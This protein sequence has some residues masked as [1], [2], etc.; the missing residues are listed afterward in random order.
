MAAPEPDRYRRAPTR[1]ANPHPSRRPRRWRVPA[2]VIP[3]TPAAALPGDDEVLRVLA[4][5]RDHGHRD[6]GH[7]VALVVGGGGM[8]GAYSG[9]MAHALED[10]GLTG[11]FDAVY[12]SSAGAFV[13]SGALLGSGRGSAHIF[14]EDMACRE[15]IDP[16]RLGT[17]RPM[18]SLDH[19]LDHVLVHSKPLP[20]D[21]LRDS[22][23]PLRVLAT[24]ADDLS[25]HVLEPRTSAEWKLALRAT[26]S[27][28][29]LA[30]PAVELA[31]R[32][33]IDGS[34]TEPL[35]VL[36]ALREGSTHVLALVNRTAPELRRDAPAGGPARWARLLDRLTP[37]LGSIA[38]QQHR[39]AAAVAL[40]DDAAHPTRRGAHLLPVVPDTDAGVRGLTTDRA[41]VEHAA[42]I[43][44]RSLTAALTRATAA[45]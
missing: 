43:G 24:A 45:A 2:T 34:V 31:G 1:H 23:V 37:G 15:F 28:P 20:W 38:Q 13:G 36:P 7:R 25:A 30:G 39:H 17:R 44:Y 9:G 10:A 12:G 21:R 35:P 27:I 6:D 16:R 5:R 18:V 32:R 41:R 42:R 11:W 22:P 29:L 4:L 3:D 40:I 33:W 26:A 8:R 19:L 14:F